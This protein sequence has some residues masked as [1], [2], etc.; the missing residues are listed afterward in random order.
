MIWFNGENKT[1]YLETEKT[2]YVMRVL[3]NGCLYHCY[4]GQKI[5]REDVTYH[6]LFKNLDFAPVFSLGAKNASYDALPQEC[7]TSGRGDFRAPAVRIQ[8]EYGQT[9]NELTYKEYRIMEG[10]PSFKEMPQ[11]DASK[12]EC[13]T[14]EIVLADIV[15]GF[16]VSLYYSVFDKENVIARRS[17]IRNVSDK[18]LKILNAASIC[19]DIENQDLEM[20]TL[21][22]AWGRER[23]V[24]RSPLHH[25]MSTVESRRGASSHQLN[26]F[27]AL[28]AKNTDEDYG[29]V[30]A[31]TLV[32]SGDF[33]ISAE[34]DHYGNLRLLAGLNPETFSWK[35]DAG[36]RFVTPEALLTYSKE[37]FGG[38]SKA[39]HAVC[40]GYL[41]KSADKKLK[42]PIVVNN[43]E[44]MYFDITEEKLIQFIEDCKGLGI[45]TMVLDD[46][47]FGHRTNDKS[48]LGDWYVN[49]DR[50]PNGLYKVIECCK[51]HGMKFGIWF[52]PEMISRDSNLFREHPDWCIHAHG[53]EGVEARN[54]LVL[55]MSRKEVC[56]AMYDMVATILNEYDIS[57]VKWDMNRHITDNGSAMLLSECQGEHSHRYILGVYYLMDRL[58]NDFPEVFFEGC[59]GGGG[60]FDFGILYYMPQ[61][62]TSDDSDAMERLKI[63]YGTSLVYPTSS[64]VAHV[65]A[66]PNHQTGRVT[67]FKTRGDVAQI[68]NFG[69]ELNIGLLSDEEKEMIKEQTAKHREIE[70]LIMDGEFYRIHS[71]FDGNTCAWQLVSKDKK[72]SYAMFARVNAVPNYKPEYLRFKGLDEEQTYRVELLGITAKG[73]TLMHAGIPIQ[74]GSGDYKTMTFDILAVEN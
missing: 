29:D 25:G 7:A 38:M 43:W 27:A 30:Y 42:H 15:N 28:V 32:Y 3:E 1:F 63:Q 41:G 50:F 36:E 4:Y 74:I 49:P 9:V 24:E 44:A 53:F 47:W 13:N 51:E 6:N 56:D 11:L 39:F 58:V 55:D 33:K 21:E 37:G 70:D 57:Y 61:I 64:M 22:G 60:R 73:S 19:L 46:G 68:C 17:V 35:L 18:S 20:V 65:S 34:K 59:S 10:K 62:W 48:S 67:P 45:D 16:E 71:P 72:K 66:C 12:G 5:G 2:S 40:R 26:P 54:Q 31:T 52:E 23:H 69:Y 8:N 14:L